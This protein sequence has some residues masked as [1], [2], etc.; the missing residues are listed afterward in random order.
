MYLTHP[1]HLNKVSELGRLAI[2]MHYK[3]GNEQDVEAFIE[4]VVLGNDDA[5]R[6]SRER[7]FNDWL[8]PP[9]NK[10]VAQN[11]FDEIEKYTHKLCPLK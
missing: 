3:G 5:M 4:N 2:D 1:G 10:T 8:L 11:M 6:A 7:F 9:H